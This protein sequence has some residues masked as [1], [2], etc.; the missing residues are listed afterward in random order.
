MSKKILSS[1]TTKYVDEMDKNIPWN[2]Y[3]RPS[4][5]RGSFLCLNGYWDFA[6]S[7]DED[8]TEL[9]KKILVPFPPESMLSGLQMEIPKASFMHYRRIFSLPDDM[10]GRKIILH[11]GAVETLCTVYLNG[12]EV[13][14]HEGGYLP[15]SFDITELCTEGE[16]TLY[17]RA[18]DDLD[19]AYP[20]GK[21]T[22]KRGGMWYTPVSGIWQTVWI[23]SVPDNYFES[24]RITTTVNEATVE[25]KGGG[26]KKKIQLDSGEIFEFYGD[27]CV[28]SPKEKHLWSPEEPY[29]YNFTLTSGED[30]VKSYFALR[31]IG[32]SV[33]NG[34]PRLTLNGKP[35][36][37]NGLLDQG[38]FPDGIFL[39]AT[40]KG[41]EDDILATKA[42][43]FNMLRKHIK[44]EPEVFYHLCD[45]LGVVVFQ[46]MINNSNY[47][48]LYDTALP[49]IGFKRLP[50]RR[51]TKR[52]QRI[53][54]EQMYATME[55]LHFFP[56]ILYYTIF[57]EGWGQFK[58]DQMYCK[59][60][61]FDP[62][63]IIDATSGWFY[64]RES[65]VDSRH[66][67]FKP[68]RIGKRGRLPI[69]ISE[70][71]GYS[72]RV[73]GHVF[74]EDN[75]GYSS[76]ETKEKLEEAIIRLYGEEIKPLI[77]QGICA[78]VYTQVS[79]VEDETNGILSYDRRVEKLNKAKICALM[80]EL[81]NE[82]STI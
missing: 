44:V 1:L 66:V 7:K 69:V 56:S 77:S 59:A 46:D 3:P 9:N 31:E 51:R 37:F 71:G 61:N 41:Y 34:I 54:E 26:D 52:E 28:I 63:R 14:K 67:Y 78:L 80:N 29:L 32:T 35:Y 47:S 55:H 30:T 23:E 33:I 74:G 38:Y 11:F 79:D 2:E 62:T 19:L 10:E 16:N 76:Y 24:I 15:F 27:K 81:Y 60:K 25:V 68:V 12:K 50:D 75:Y 20:Y 40:S 49:T 18:R 6:V 8:S 70:F 53:F 13:G 64:R 45:K 4:M 73:M 82:V 72:H 58:A 42:H 48:F 43:G 5:V 21:Q 39:P 17:V 57:N 22:R 65:D 36:L